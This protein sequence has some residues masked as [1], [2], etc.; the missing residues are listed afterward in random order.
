MHLL[1]NSLSGWHASHTHV[2]NRPCQAH[3][4]D[5][6]QKHWR[7]GREPHVVQSKLFIHSDSHVNGQRSTAN[8]IQEP[9]KHQLQALFSRGAAKLDA[10]NRSNSVFELTSRF[11]SIDSRF[12]PSLVKQSR[13]LF[14]RLWCSESPQT[15]LQ[16]RFLPKSGLR[17]LYCHPDA[18][19]GPDLS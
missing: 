4:S 19:I 5:R 3:V 6:K 1:I 16:V 8:L 11:D 7:L 10:Q 9:S 18:R 14:D 2:T 15:A 12:H 13:S 17:P